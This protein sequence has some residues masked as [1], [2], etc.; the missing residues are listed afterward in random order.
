MLKT[1]REPT[2]RELEAKDQDTVASTTGDLRR[3]AFKEWQA[4]RLGNTNSRTALNNLAFAKF[5][6]DTVKVEISAAKLNLVS[7]PAVTFSS[8]IEQ[9]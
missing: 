4:M 7:I 9:E 1:L 3:Q 6:L 8:P 2:S 5:I